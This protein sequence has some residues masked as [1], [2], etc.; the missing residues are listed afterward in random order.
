ML[1]SW[2][3]RHYFSLIDVKGKNIN[4]TCTLCP[5]TKCSTSTVS[6]SNL[7]KHLL[8]AHATIKLVARVDDASAAASSMPAN[9]E[10]HGEGATPSDQQKLDFSA[11]ADG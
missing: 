8:K 10:E 5:R 2:E 7:M 1:S 6:N 3:Y 9:K 11:S 4:V